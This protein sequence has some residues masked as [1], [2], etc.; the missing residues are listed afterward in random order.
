MLVGLVVFMGCGSKEEA[1][2]QTSDK[3]ASAE[4]GKTVAKAPE[5]DF[6][7]VQHI[8]IGFQGSVPGKPITRTKEEAKKLADEILKRAKDGEDFDAL[9]KEYTNDSHPGIYKMSNRGV[10]PTANP[11]QMFP[12]E[13]MVPAFGDVGFPLEVGGIGMAEWDQQK[14]PFG[15]HI[16]KRLD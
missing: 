10:T 6:I 1:A 16:I 11:P 7:T 2:E 9:V 12:R 13:R 8:L 4:P 15:W 14:S 3:Q 5:P